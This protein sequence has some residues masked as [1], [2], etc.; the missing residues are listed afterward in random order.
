MTEAAARKISDAIN[1][2][3]LNYY[4]AGRYLANDH[5]TLQQ[6]FMRLAVEFI[7]QEASKNVFHFDDRNVETVKLCKEIQIVFDRLGVYLPK[8]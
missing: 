3:G 7:S 8:I 4:E 1:D 2:M 6:N 5:P